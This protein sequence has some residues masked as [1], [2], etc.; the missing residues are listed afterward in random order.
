MEKSE[1]EVRMK[2]VTIKSAQLDL[3]FFSA[4]LACFRDSLAGYHICPDPCD[5]VYVDD[6]INC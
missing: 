3:I 5:A 1:D 2:I 4:C 6:D